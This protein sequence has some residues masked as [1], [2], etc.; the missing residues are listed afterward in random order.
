M[1][2]LYLGLAGRNESANIAPPTKARRIE[3]AEHPPHES[4]QQPV[5]QNNEQSL[6][7]RQWKGPGSAIALLPPTEPTAYVQ[8]PGY[9]PIQLVHLEEPPPSELPNAKGNVTFVPLNPA[10][11]AEEVRI[12]ATEEGISLS[13]QEAPLDTVL[14]LIAEQH[15]LNVV[16]GQSVT[17]TIT[18]K[19]SNV[20]VEDAL[21]AI[22]GANGYVW[23][24][25]QNIIT[26]SKIT[27]ESRPAPASQGRQVQIFTLNYVTAVDVDKVIKGL[28]SPVGQ[29]FINEAI[30]TDHRRAHEQVVVEDLPDYLSRIEAYLQQ[31]DRPPRQVLIEAHVLEVTLKGG[32]RFGVDLKHLFRI[33]NSD[34]TV[35]T[36]GM[37]PGLVPVSL[38]K[39]DGNQLDGMLEA[40]QSTT[41]AKTLASPKVAVLNGQEANMQ[42]GSKIG[43]LLT[44]TTQTSSLQSVNFLDVGVIL[45]V[46]PTITADGQILMHVKPQ[47]STGGINATT[48]LPE[49]A[50]TELETRVMVGDGE[51]VVIGGLIKEVE[52]KSEVKLP[53][54]GDIWLVGWLFKHRTT[55]RE[56]REIIVT[57]L[58]RIIPAETGYR[59]FDPCKVEQAH[60]PLFCGSLRP[61]DRTAFEAGAPRYTVHDL[62]QPRPKRETA[63][64]TCPPLPEY[65][66]P[67]PVE[68]LPYMQYQ[69]PRIEPPRRAV[70]P[71]RDDQQLDGPLRL[72]P[73]GPGD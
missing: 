13:A 46:T 20:R 40:L 34:V 25:Q 12:S 51:A 37:A 10:S 8:Q 44:T 41:D 1:L 57:L 4:F 27:A 73:T 52:D 70:D 23:T 2:M 47:V 62:W 43:Y 30:P 31:A 69:F 39:I 9:A 18:V 17:G 45:G 24:R 72:P 19:L 28:L 35:Q 42:V 7:A 64:E 65:P 38:I 66:V 15:G 50:T 54:L 3:I 26:V 59:N 48:Q 32:C 53:I 55:V 11:V 36:I 60:T 56:R 16:A 63:C 58:P 5:V 33:A 49:S 61:V 21:D 14:S 71:G 22:L 67:Q 68:Q 29:S 6:P